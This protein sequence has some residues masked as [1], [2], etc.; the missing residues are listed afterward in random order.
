VGDIA[1]SIIGWLVI[2]ALVGVFL[3]FP[4]F[5]EDRV[6]YQLWVFGSS[7]LAGLGFVIFRFL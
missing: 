2:V 4:N 6:L 5:R 1:G 7:F 3:H